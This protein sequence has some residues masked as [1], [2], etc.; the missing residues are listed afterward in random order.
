M[1]EWIY[2]WKAGHWAASQKLIFWNVDFWFSHSWSSKSMLKNQEKVLVW[3][4]LINYRMQRS[5]SL[6]DR[7]TDNDSRRLTKCNYWIQRLGLL[8]MN[9]DFNQLISAQGLAGR[10]MVRRKN[11]LMAAS[12]PIEI[13]FAFPGLPGYTPGRCPGV[14]QKLKSSYNIYNTKPE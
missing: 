12:K 1:I 10:Q 3:P 13:L 8:F 2:I 6:I 14:Y 11:T 7:E 9:I 4:I 5:D